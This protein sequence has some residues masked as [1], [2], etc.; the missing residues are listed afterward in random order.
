[1]TKKI[2]F[3]KK[4]N[5]IFTLPRKFYFLDSEPTQDNEQTQHFARK[6]QDHKYSALLQKN[7]KLHIK[8]KT[9]WFHLGEKYSEKFVE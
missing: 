7:H 2:K 5:E 6:N 3:E 1:L 9:Y 4:K 8:N